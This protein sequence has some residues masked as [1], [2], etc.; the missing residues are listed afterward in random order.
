M[1]WYTHRFTI[2]VSCRQAV[3]AIRTDKDRVAEFLSTKATPNPVAVLKATVLWELYKE[4]YK[5]NYPSGS[6]MGSRTFYENL[7]AIP[8]VKKHEKRDGNY[9]SGYELKE[10]LTHAEA[11]LERQKLLHEINET[12]S[13]I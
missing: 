6:L 1:D 9:Y 4:W 5:A 3:D 8:G 11:L 7:A 2:P 12:I 13:P 10:E